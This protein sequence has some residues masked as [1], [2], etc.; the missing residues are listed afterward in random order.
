MLAHVRDDG[1]VQTV[2]EHCE[3]VAL[4]ASQKAERLGFFHTAKLCGLLHDFGKNTHPFQEHLF[5]EG[6]E[7]VNHSSAGARYLNELVRPNTPIE[8]LTLQIISLIIMGHHGLLDVISEGRNK[9]LERMMTEENT[10]YEEAYANRD[11]DDAVILEEFYFACLE[12]EAAFSALRKI[13]SKMD[14]KKD[15]SVKNARLSEGLGNASDLFFLTG[16]LE[17]FLLS[18]V[19]DA[20]RED[21]A[22]FMKNSSLKEEKEETYNTWEK[23]Q[24]LL[25]EKLSLMPKDTKINKLRKEISDQCLKAAERGDGIYKLSAPTGSGKTYSCLRYGLELAKNTGKERIIYVAPYVNILEQNAQVY[26][27]VLED[28]ENILEHHCGIASE[29]KD[30]PFFSETWEQKLIITTMVQLLNAMFDVKTKAIRRLH[31]LENAV[32]IIDEAQKIPVNCINL[33][34]SFCNF[35]NGFCYSTILLCTATQPLFEMTSHPLLYSDHPDVLNDANKY[36][37]EFRRTKD[38][39]HKE[40]MTAKQIADFADSI[41][42]RDLLP[43][44]KNEVVHDSLLIVLN[45]KKIVREVYDEIRLKFLLDD[46]FTYHLTTSMCPAHRL[47]VISEIKDR[48]REG[49]GVILVSTP[50]VDA[51]VDVSFHKLIRDMTGVDDLVQATGRCNRN[52]EWED[53]GICH[54]VECTEGRIENLTDVYVGRNVTNLLLLKNG[55][56]PFDVLANDVLSSFYKQ[57]FYDRRGDMTYPVKNNNLYSMLSDNV[58]IRNDYGLRNGTPFP[59]GLL[60]QSFK[61][62]G[63]EF[64][65]IDEKDQVAVIVPYGEGKAL[66]N[67]LLSERNWGEQKRILRRL[68]KYSVNVYE[69]DSIYREIK[70]ANGILVND[71]FGINVLLPKFYGE[72]GIEIPSPEREPDFEIEF[73]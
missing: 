60:S 67:S 16:C 52:G 5:S 34:N 45:T 55:N 12:M 38:V 44:G 9:Y 35:L 11:F 32:I 54:F 18:C 1:T 15:P 43:K 51:G 37:S 30:D 8:K 68:Q 66:I 50:L 70:N 26:R 7:H 65:V 6:D 21:T 4:L 48:L 31:R 23:W 28:D 61:T 19:I 27:D 13:S 39:F 10:H 40:K 69:T 14:Q 2:K 33:F 73:H 42:E 22:S 64:H 72:A 57:K 46:V 63:E 59:N 58:K 71:D 25:N 56:K 41:F 53:G 49:K 20:D 36:V 24:E 3:N 62:A 29:N 17:R 47:D